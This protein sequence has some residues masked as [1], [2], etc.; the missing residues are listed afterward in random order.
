[1]EI[2]CVNFVEA[3]KIIPFDLHFIV[4]F[5]MNRRNN[6]VI[7]WESQPYAFELTNVLVAA[8]INDRYA[9]VC[10]CKISV[11]CIAIASNYA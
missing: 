3:S 1:M 4:D 6:F 9:V 10:L 8:V 7:P 2:V 5:L 11:R